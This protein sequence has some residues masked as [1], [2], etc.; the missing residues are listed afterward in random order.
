MFE[1][2]EHLGR[3]W[4]QTLVTYRLEFDLAGHPYSGPDSV[5]VSL[6]D[7]YSEEFTL[8]HDPELTG[9]THI[10]RTVNVDEGVLARLEFA[11]VGADNEG[12][13]L[14][15]VRLVR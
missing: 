11:Q 8:P 13:L 5:T 10:N 9:F 14:D 7:V 15:N 3:D 2:V 6:G 4:A 1:C 12:V